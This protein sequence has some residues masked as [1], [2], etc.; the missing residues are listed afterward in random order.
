MS[1]IALHCGISLKPLIIKCF[2]LQQKALH[3]GWLNIL[4][5]PVYP[6]LNQKAMRGA[7]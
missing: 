1:L 3:V 7:D 4:Y 2:G 6:R 5:L